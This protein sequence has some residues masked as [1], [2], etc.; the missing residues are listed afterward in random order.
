MIAG[1]CLYAPFGPF[2]A[3]APD[4]MPR[5]AAGVSMALVNGLGGLG[6]FVGTYLVGF[7]NGATGSPNMSFIVMACALFLAGLCNLPVNMHPQ[8]SQSQPDTGIEL[9]LATESNV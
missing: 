2:Y 4:I 1:G 5:E 9:E 8:H 3:I 7:L 6:S